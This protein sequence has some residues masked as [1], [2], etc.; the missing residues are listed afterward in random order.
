MKTCEPHQQQHSGHAA[1]RNI[2]TRWQRRLGRNNADDE[3]IAVDHLPAD[4]CRGDFENWAL[5]H[6]HT[7][8]HADTKRTMNQKVVTGVLIAACSFSLG[9]GA[10][11]MAIASTVTEHTSEIRGLRDTD[12]LIRKELAEERQRTDQRVAQIATLMGEMVRQ[13][14]EFINLLKVQNQILERRMP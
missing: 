9:F 14:Q 3:R 12:A 5:T 2:Y 11:Q 4:V 8:T 1:V 10:S 6:T 7:H 13:N